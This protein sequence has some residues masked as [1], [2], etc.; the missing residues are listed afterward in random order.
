MCAI[1][2]GETSTCDADAK[3]CE[4]FGLTGG[5][6]NSV[7]YMAGATKPCRLQPGQANLAKTIVQASPRHFTS[8]LD[9]NRFEICLIAAA[10]KTNCNLIHRVMAEQAMPTS[11]KI[12]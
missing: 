7:P 2:P 1:W 3:Q 6:I 4:L 10:V 11:D 8:L 5:V 9:H 12:Q